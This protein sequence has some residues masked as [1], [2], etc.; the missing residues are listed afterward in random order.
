MP[1]SLSSG[2]TGMYAGAILA[3]RRDITALVP[4]RE[5][6]LRLRM[7]RALKCSTQV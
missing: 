6:T 3:L 7:H 1:L 2:M 5:V 4:A